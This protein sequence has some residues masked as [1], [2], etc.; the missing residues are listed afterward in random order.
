MRGGSGDDR[1]QGS[2]AYEGGRNALHGGPGD[3]TLLGAG[4]NDDFW[5]E[6]GDDFVRGGDSYG[7]D[8]VHYENATA[9]MHVDL[10]AESATGQGADILRGI[11]DVVG[12]PQA[13][14][15]AGSDGPGRDQRNT[16][17][18]N[19]G[20]DLLLG[21]EAATS[22]STASSAARTPAAPTS[23]AEGHKATS[24]GLGAATT[25]RSADPD[26]TASA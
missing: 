5:P 7:L 21:E 22:W 15:I 2:G 11:K 8:V 18:G 17:E 25:K 3:D 14:F 4:A 12:S 20:A 23:S 10:R 1:L 9:S 24:S 13:D 6:A 19:G 16:L 26:A